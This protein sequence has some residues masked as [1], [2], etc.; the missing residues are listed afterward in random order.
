[1]HAQL[2]AEAS[3]SSS[4]N[5][6]DS[7]LLRVQTTSVSGRAVLKIAQLHAREFAAKVR[8][9]GEKHAEP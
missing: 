5:S 1:M 2:E 7:R 8:R 3:S 6:N 4:Q 9:R